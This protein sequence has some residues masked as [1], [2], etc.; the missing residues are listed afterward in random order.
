MIAPLPLQL[1]AQAVPMLTRPELAALTERLIE[2]LDLLDGDPDLEPEEDS[3]EAGDD[4]CGMIIR[5][6][7][8]FWGADYAASDI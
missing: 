3:C 7:V 1:L 8:R 5:H 6:G 4:G 2:R